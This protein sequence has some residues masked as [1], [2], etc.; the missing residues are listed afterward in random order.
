M[1]TSWQILQRLSIFE[2]Y[3]YSVIREF[4]YSYGE[5]TIW[6]YEGGTTSGVSTIEIEETDTEIIIQA[7]ISDIEAEN[8]EVQ[9]SPETALIKGKE[10]TLTE[11]FSSFDFEFCPSQ[12]QIVIPLPSLI[13]PH[14]TIAE[15]NDGIL[16]LTFQKSYNKKRLIKVKIF[17]TKDYAPE[18]SL[19][20]DAA[21]GMNWD[22]LSLVF[23]PS[24]QCVGSIN[25]AK[26]S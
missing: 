6:I 4:L 26:S 23:S 25:N 17:D 24:E 9:V 13:Q 12:F 7:D 16:K 10:V 18:P 19:A 2:Q 21:L 14:A 20:V 3:L 15:F 22:K 1:L 5:D 8:L 11:I